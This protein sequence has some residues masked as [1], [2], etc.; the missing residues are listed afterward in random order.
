[1]LFHIDTN[2]NIQNVLNMLNKPF[3]FLCSLFHFV[4]IYIVS[5]QMMRVNCDTAQEFYLQTTIKDKLK[6][7][8]YVH[9]KSVGTI[10][11]LLAT[12]LKQLKEDISHSSTGTAELL[13][14]IVTH[15][16]VCSSIKY[17]CVLLHFHMLE[18]HI[19]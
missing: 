19:L 2:V 4:V 7:F 14:A 9:P 8:S 18:N 11:L 3:L 1:M 16:G 17:S 12:D 5:L 10:L 15:L 13:V 6:G